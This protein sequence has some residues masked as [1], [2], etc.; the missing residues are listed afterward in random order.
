MRLVPS[1]DWITPAISLAKCV[2][3]GRRPI[4]VF[5]NSRPPAY[6]QRMLEDA[7]IRASPGGVHSA[8]FVLLVPFG[9][10]LRARDLLWGV[11]APLA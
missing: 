8:G 10:E 3:G 6:W 7:G 2:A 4:S 1:L 9:D 5:W 11:G